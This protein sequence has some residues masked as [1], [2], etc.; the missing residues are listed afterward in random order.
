M[1]HGSIE[2]SLMVFW[3]DGLPSRRCVDPSLWSRDHAARLAHHRHRRFD[4]KGS[5]I[6]DGAMH[7]T[8][9]LTVGA[10]AE[11]RDG[12][13]VAVPGNLQLGRLQQRQR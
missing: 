3:G 7:E 12:V 5:S 6:S 13:T 8:K 11:H 1:H 9:F 10:L 4:G 2:T